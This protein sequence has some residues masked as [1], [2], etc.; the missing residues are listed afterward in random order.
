MKSV[1]EIVSRSVILLCL[2][3]RCALEESIIEGIKY[4]MKQ[5]EEQRLAIYDWLKSKGYITWMTNREK[6]IFE[7]RVGSESLSEIFVNQIQYEAIEPCLWALGLQQMLSSYDEFVL[8]DFHPILQIGR[9]HSVE[10]IIQICKLRSDKSIQLQNEI[11]AL[12]HWRSIESNNQIFET[13]SAQDIII[14][15]FGINYLE[16]LEKIQDFNNTQNDF[17]VNG[18]LF[19]N[20]NDKEKERINY[21]AKWRH[22]AFEW[23]I[24]DV[25]WDEVETNT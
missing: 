22:H 12:W 2:S 8:E 13:T 10:K 1:C 14:E 5:R 25:P 15:V 9:E 23:I 21:I 19:K 3:D 24:S 6:Q 18:K 11:S 20:L 17:V 4:T 7:T 16:I